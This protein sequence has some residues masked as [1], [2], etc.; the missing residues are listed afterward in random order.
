MHHESI[1]IDFQK[2]GAGPMSTLS[3]AALRERERERERE[4]LLAECLRF[5]S[6]YTLLS[7]L[8][9]LFAH[10]SSSAEEQRPRMFS[11]SSSCRQQMTKLLSFFEPALSPQPS[12]MNHLQFLLAV[13]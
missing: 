8:S 3:C 1:I 11:S 7:P 6:Y 10:P 2:G 13:V 5:S 12:E 9:F 4:D